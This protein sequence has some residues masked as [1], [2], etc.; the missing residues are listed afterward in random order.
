MPYLFFLTLLEVYASA[1]VDF[2]VS[3]FDSLQTFRED[4]TPIDGANSICLSAA[5]GETEGFQI[6][7]ANWSAETLR[8]ISVSIQG[9]SGVAAT[10]YAEGSIEIEKASHSSQ[11]VPGRHFDLLRPAGWETIESGTHRPYWVDLRIPE[12][13]VSPGIYQSEVVVS[14]GGLTRSIHLELRVFG[15]SLPTTPTL[16]LAFAFVPQWIEQYYERELTTREIRACQDVMLDHHLGPVNMWSSGEELFDSDTLE[17]C[18]KRGMNVVLLK[19]G[20]TTDTAMRESLEKLLPRIEMLESLG[21]LDRAYLFGYDEILEHNPEHIPAM[22]RMYEMFHAKFP[23]IRRITTSR[24]DDRLM[25]FVDIFVPHTR[26]FQPDMARDAKVW[27]YTTGGD[28]LHLEPGFRIDY[29][30][31][32]QRG[33]FLADWKN[34]VTGHLYWAMTREWPA[35]KSIKDKSLPE[36]EWITGYI[37]STDGKWAKDNGGGNLFYPDGAGGMLPT[38][39]VKRI[40]DG[41]EDYVY[42]AQLRA[43]AK[44]LEEHRPAGWSKLAESAHELLIIPEEVIQGKTAITRD[45]TALLGLREHVGNCLEACALA[46]KDL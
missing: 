9:P 29:P 45:A 5:L 46:L 42:F 38:S 11:S 30:G 20:G 34:D 10:V 12:E 35:N 13:G 8:D 3:A 31:T 18:L 33:F 1:A 32:V 39:R 36:R 15:F 25:D 41:I 21:A 28:R 4:E 2:H 7:V 24:P 16:K 22:R 27:W 26:H 44:L 6:V 17:H 19:C 43:V 40:R 23:D 37:R 14:T